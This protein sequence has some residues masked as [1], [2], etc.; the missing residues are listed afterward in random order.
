LPFPGGAAGTAP[1]PDGVLALDIDNDFKGDLVLAGGAGVRPVPATG[2]RRLHRRH[3]AD[4][5]SPGRLE[6]ALHRRRGRSDVEADGD[7]DVLLGAAS[8]PPLVL[9]N[10]GDGSFV[11]QQTVRGVSGV[12]QFAWADL[13][14]DGDPDAA[15]VDAAGRLRVFDNERSRA[16]PRARGPGGSWAGFSP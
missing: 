5:A 8:G 16:V 9:R 3:R 14:G 6:R 11:V 1:T 12:R 13:D 4:T 7:L 15:L 10:N 2:E